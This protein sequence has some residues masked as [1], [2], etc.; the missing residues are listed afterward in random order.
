MDKALLIGKAKNIGLGAIEDILKELVIPFIK[1]KV[2]DTESK[3]DDMIF[4]ALEV[5]LL[6]LIDQLDGEI[7]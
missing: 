7:G 4:G 5:E 3:I 1:D 6:K 2:E